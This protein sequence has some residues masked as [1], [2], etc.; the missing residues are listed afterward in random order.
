MERVKL[1]LLLGQMYPFQELGPRATCF[2]AHQIRSLAPRPQ[3]P[4]L[5]GPKEILLTQAGLAPPHP[6]AVTS[7]ELHSNVGPEWQHLQTPMYLPNPQPASWAKCTLHRAAGIPKE[8]EFTNWTL[9]SP[10]LRGAR[11]T[12]VWR[13]GVWPGCSISVTV[14]SYVVSL[15]APGCGGRSRVLF[16]FTPGISGQALAGLISLAS[17]P[18]GGPLSSALL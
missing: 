15:E 4:S 6:C 11:G 5:A 12:E 13:P 8:A 14:P 9:P 17:C 3:Y 7:L 2:F 1:W 16:N 18:G 10:P